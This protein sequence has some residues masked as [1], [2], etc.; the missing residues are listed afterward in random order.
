MQYHKILKIRTPKYRYCPT[1]EDFKF[2]YAL[3]SPKASHGMG[4][5]VGPDQTAPSGAV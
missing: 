5:S 4:N 3:I 2:F 1:N